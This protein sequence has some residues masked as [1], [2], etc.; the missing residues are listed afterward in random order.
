MSSRLKAFKRIIF[1][2]YG[3]KVMVLSKSVLITYIISYLFFK[4]NLSPT[5]PHRCVRWCA[6]TWNNVA[7][8]KWLVV[9]HTGVGTYVYVCCITT[10]DQPFGHIIVFLIVKSWE[11]GVN[12]LDLEVNPH[13]FQSDWY[14]QAPY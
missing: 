1:T 12:C 10:G 5:Y 6:A 8:V 11:P 3:S 9:V 2:A 7:V 13:T 4:I 14:H